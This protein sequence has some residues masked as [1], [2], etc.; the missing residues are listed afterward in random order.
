MKL[1]FGAMYL[2]IG[3][4]GASMDLGGLPVYGVLM[5]DA[6]DIKMCWTSHEKTSLCMYVYVEIYYNTGKGPTMVEHL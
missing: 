1:F 6:G 3:A 2:F 5:V 4:F